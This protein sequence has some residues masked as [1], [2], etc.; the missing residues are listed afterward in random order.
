MAEISIN[1]SDRTWALVADIGERLFLLLIFA[2]FIAHVGP[3]LVTEPHNWLI[4]VAEAFTALLVLI[5]KPG[6]PAGGIYAWTV[7]VI[8]TC[9]GLMV[10]PNGHPV[11]AAGV[12][13]TMMFMGMTM[14]LAAKLFLNRSFGMVAA[15]RGVKRHGPYRIVRHP[16]YLGY[17]IAQG[18]FLLLHLSVWNLC[19]YAAAWTALLLR[20]ET[21]E[22]YL[23]R[24]ER[25]REYAAQVPYRLVP[26]LI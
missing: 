6:A 8:G 23:R 17:M 7:A 24:D 26:G 25:Y 20:I 18:G 22:Q 16:M 11:V 10:L 1:E 15:N 2:W 12:G 9:A 13:T 19:V 14:S 3:S 21:E 5:R 4:V